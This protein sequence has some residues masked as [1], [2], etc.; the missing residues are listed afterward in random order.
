[1]FS[2]SGLPNRSNHGS[3]PNRDAVSDG[4]DADPY[5]RPRRTLRTNDSSSMALSGALTLAGQSHARA[6][7]QRLNGG[8]AAVRMPQRMKRQDAKHAKEIQVRL[9]TLDSR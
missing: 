8:P 7:G 3:K 5:G 2:R 1:M 4:Q 9:R 6:T